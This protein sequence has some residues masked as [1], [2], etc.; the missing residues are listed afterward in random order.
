MPEN[1][2]MI[3]ILVVAEIVHKIIAVADILFD[4]EEVYPVCFLVNVPKKLYISLHL[5]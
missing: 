3:V 5:D 4:F 1:M 2:K